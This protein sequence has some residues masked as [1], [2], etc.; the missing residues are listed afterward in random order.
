M[1][2]AADNLW[3]EDFG[4]LK[5]TVPPI[6]ILNQQAAFLGQMTKN[7]LEGEVETNTKDYERFL[8]HTL[9]I[10]APVL[11][12][13]RYPLLDVEHSA[14]RMYPATIN[15]IWL[16]KQGDDST[17]EIQATT[18]EELK[19]G[20]K[21]VFADEETKKVLSSLLIQSQEA[22]KVVDNQ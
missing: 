8:H 20:L 11:N 1:S 22:K 6:T 4:I 3:P 2:S 7:I 21:R 14:T 16:D 10:V 5:E 12:F 17:L 19:E 18:E 15:V 9:Y 13:Y